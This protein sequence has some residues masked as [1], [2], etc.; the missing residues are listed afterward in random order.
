M[1]RMAE[2]LARGLFSSGCRMGMI[3]VV[4]VVIGS[5]YALACTVHVLSRTGLDLN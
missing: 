1:I 3:G 4:V 2:Q 5:M